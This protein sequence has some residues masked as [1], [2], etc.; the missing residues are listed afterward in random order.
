MNKLLKDS[1]EKL[2]QDFP[3]L[4]WDY[5][6]VAVNGSTEKL[7]YWIGEENENIMVCVLKDY[8]M[9]E[10]FH[11]HGFFFLNYAYVGDYDAISY[12]SDNKITIKQNECY[13]GQPFS[14]YALRTPKESKSIVVGVLV[15]KELFFKEFLAVIASDSNLFRF[16]LSSQNDKFSEDF[17]H[18][19]FPEY[20]PVRS[21]LEMMIIEYANKKEDTQFV[22]KNFTNVILLHIARRYREV[23]PEP[24]NLTLCDKIL[25]YVGEHTDTA[26]LNTIARYFSYH[27]NYVSAL[28]KNETGKTFSEHLLKFRMDKAVMLLKGTSLSVEEIAVMLGYSNNSNF[29]KAF[30]EYYGVSPRE[31]SQP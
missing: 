24:L 16:F 2:A 18:F 29:Y 4:N 19:S 22:L 7:L 6:D 9:Q 11:R 28:L 20:S 13:I 14:G 17:I 23:N 3:N 27:P 31:Y 25:R 12:K 15:K 26:T 30:R 5:V 8:E 21:L 1:I 10:H